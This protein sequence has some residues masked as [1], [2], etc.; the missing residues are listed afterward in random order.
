MVFLFS[1]GGFL[2][3]RLRE[4]IDKLNRELLELLGKRTEIALEIGRIKRE[5][6]QDVGDQKREKAILESVMVEN[7]GPLPESS[8]KRIFLTIMEET[9]RAEREVVGDDSR[10]ETGCE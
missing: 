5:Q 9:R 8:V 3:D 4:K 1:R 10:N 6:G 7:S 2:I